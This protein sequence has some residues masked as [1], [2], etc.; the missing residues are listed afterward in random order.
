MSRTGY[1][2]RHI[3]DRL[4]PGAAYFEPMPALN[5]VLYCHEGSF[6]VLGEEETTISE[7]RAWFGTGDVTVRAGAEGA[8]IWRYELARAHVP[9]KLAAGT[10]VSSEMTLEAALDDP[11]PGG[12]WL[13]RCDAVKF[14]LGGK[15]F[16][17]IHQGPGIR[18]VKTGRLRIEMGGGSALY[19]PGQTWFEPGPE[20]VIAHACEQECTKFVRVM[21]L[22]ADLKGKSSIQ[23]VNPDDFEK[24]KTQ[25]YQ[26]Y[27]DE[28]IEH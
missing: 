17:H 15:A 8:V 9:V 1:K 4:A 19:E 20:P 24:P 16:A 5:R 23:Y 26:H 2:L 21:V 6:T 11:D 3:V 27:V 22:P 14:P 13:L 7:D 18:C 25:R 10:G 12:D 28:P